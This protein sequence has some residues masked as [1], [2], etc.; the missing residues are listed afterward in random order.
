MPYDAFGKPITKEKL[1]KEQQHFEK[2]YKRIA[3]ANATLPAM[4]GFFFVAGVLG[5]GAKLVE[6]I[7]TGEPQN[8]V[9]GIGGFAGCLGLFLFGL[10]ESR[11]DPL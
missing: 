1:E 8:M 10:I 7:A 5:C 4:A 2:H 11:I 6:L 9:L 3:V